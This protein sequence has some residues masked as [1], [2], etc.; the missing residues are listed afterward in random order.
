MALT[1]PH[2]GASF[3]CMSI[4]IVGSSPPQSS[5]AP[6]SPAL[7]TVAPLSTVATSM[8]PQAPSRRHHCRHHHRTIAATI[9]AVSIA[10]AIVTTIW[11]TCR[12]VVATA[13]ALPSQPHYSQRHNPLLPQR[14]PHA[15]GCC[16][17][18][19][20][21]MSDRRAELQLPQGVNKISFSA[22]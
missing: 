10:T 15:A 21:V 7:P 11:C 16:V 13:I 14:S 2:R 19:C 17:S 18:A 6:S 20:T 3:S 5:P 22:T 9:A 4:V 8:P 12:A 1:W